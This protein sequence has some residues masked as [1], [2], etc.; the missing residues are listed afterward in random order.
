[1]RKTAVFTLA[2]ALAV[3]L[4]PLAARPAGAIACPPG[5]KAC[6]NM[7]CIPIT[8]KCFINCEPG[9]AL[10]PAATTR[11]A[12]LVPGADAAGAGDAARAVFLESLWLESGAAPPP[13]LLC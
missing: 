10:T 5:Y 2:L 11:L 8:F 3:L 12:S 4:S 9:L 6:C 13:F 1:M 7:T